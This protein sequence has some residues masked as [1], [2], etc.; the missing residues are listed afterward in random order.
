MS[1]NT[2]IGIIRDTIEDYKNYIKRLCES[3]DRSIN[4]GEI[5]AAKA[6]MR[7]ILELVEEM[8]GA[9]EE[10]IGT[11]EQEINDMVGDFERE[12]EEMDRE[13]RQEIA[14]LRHEI[15]SYRHR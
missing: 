2:S 8:K 13:Y 10:S 11:V 5:D 15:R 6:S 9:V 4:A 14:S 7:E 3:M 12:K 1:E